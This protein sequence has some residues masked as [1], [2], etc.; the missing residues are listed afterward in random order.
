MRYSHD[1]SAARMLVPA[2]PG[3]PV[4]GDLMLLLLRNQ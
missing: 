2:S 4:E 3:K 1:T